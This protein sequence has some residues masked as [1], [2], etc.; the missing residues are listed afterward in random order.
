M[1]EGLDGS[2]E[3]G[4]RLKNE[5]KRQTYNLIKYFYLVFLLCKFFKFFGGFQYTQSVFAETCPN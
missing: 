5:I 4:K 1:F 3:P 2:T